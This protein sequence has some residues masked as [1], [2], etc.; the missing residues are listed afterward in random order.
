MRYLMA[1][2]LAGSM[3][4]FAHHASA[5]D[6]QMTIAVFT[7][8]STNPA[9]EAFRIAADQIARTSGTK[10]VHFVPKQPDNVDEQKAMVEQVIKDRPD[11]I[12]FI[13]VDDV[14]M[15]PSVKLLNEAKIPVILVSNPLPG[16]FVTYVGADDFEIGYREARYLFEH[17][18]GKGKIVVIEGT[19]AAPTNRERL[20]GYQRAFGEFPGIEV[21]GSAVGNYQTPDARRGMEK[22]L[23]EHKQIDA[24]LSA[25]D[26]LALGV[27]DALKTANRSAIVIGINGILPAVKQIEAGGMLASVDFNMFKIGCTATRAAVRHLKREPLPEKVMLPAEVIDK[28]NYKAWLVPVDQRTCPD[29]SEVVR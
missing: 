23:A 27:L 24:V 18:G 29:W 13:P 25:N 5:A 11:A 3:A 16:S 7:K 15:I 20:R 9:Y 10:V 28:T 4:L 14:A 22:L 17:L 12:I 26:S 21:L 19:P 6:N 1:T 8:N 2:M